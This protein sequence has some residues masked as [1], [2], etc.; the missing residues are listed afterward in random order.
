M[1]APTDPEGCEEML[2][3]TMSYW[4]DWI[5]DCDANGSDGSEGNDDGGSDGDGN[6]AC[7]FDGY[8]HDA[9]V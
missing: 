4:R 7:P 2:E 9:V 5:H 6:G 1:K 8:A 3:R